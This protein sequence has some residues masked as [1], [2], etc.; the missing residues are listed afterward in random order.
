MKLTKAQIAA[1]SKAESLISS[2]HPL[3]L[4]EREFILDNYHP[5][6]R[7]IN[8]V[9]GAYFTPRALAHDLAIYIPDH[10]TVIDLCAGIGSLAYQA[11]LRA[12]HSD[13]YRQYRSIPIGQI[14]CIEINP[15]Y[16]AVGRR[17]VPEAIWIQ[18]DIFSLPE[19][20][21]TRPGR[22]PGEAFDFAICNP[23]FGR[24]KALYQSGSLPYP[25]SPIEL[26]VLSIAARLA[27]CGAF[28]L[29][30]MSCPFTYSGQP[31]HE[32]RIT[33]VWSQFYRQSHIDLTASSIDCAIYHDHWRDVSPNVEIALYD[34][35]ESPEKWP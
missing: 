33:P 27:R 6:A 32:H 35:D 8:S 26:S 21:F 7:H 15:D 16:I 22:L 3:S 34:L 29:P 31:Y 10:G 18:A 24:S 23:P 17:V 13:Y 30:Q 5:A 20:I 12:Y 1:H 2:S 11:V 9:H 28:I 25:G 14:T 19:S 4:D